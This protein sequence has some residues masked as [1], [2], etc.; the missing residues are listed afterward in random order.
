MDKPIQT[1]ALQTRA[2]LLEIGRAHF[3]RDGVS[4]LRVEQIVAEAGVAKGTFFSHFG[5]KEGLLTLL[6]GERMTAAL[7][8]IAAAAPP[9]AP[10]EFAT[11]LAPLMAEMAPDAQTFDI[12]LRHSGATGTDEEGPIARNF[13]AQVEVLTGWIARLQPD[14]VRADADPALLAEG[15]QAFMAHAMALTFCALHSATG[16]DARLRPFLRTWLAPL[17]VR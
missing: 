15:V 7:D 10:D 17:P 16:I 8:R 14:A 9:D 2:R 3:M 5:D 13:L 1:R 12:V 6:I 4:G 11:A